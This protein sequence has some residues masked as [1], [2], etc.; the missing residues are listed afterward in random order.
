M[1][2]IPKIIVNN[3]KSIQQK[4]LDVYGVRCE[5]YGQRNALINTQTDIWTKIEN[6]QTQILKL[7]PPKK[8]RYSSN[9]S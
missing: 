6:I 9:V 2:I 5:L 1:S 3:T 7:E 4:K 8:K